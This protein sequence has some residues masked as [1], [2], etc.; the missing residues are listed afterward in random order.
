MT[1]YKYCSSLPGLDLPNDSDCY[2]PKSH[3]PPAFWDTLSK[4]WLTEDALRE[5]NRR[6]SL[7]TSNVPGPQSSE[8][9]TRRPVTRQIF[10]ERKRNRR[11]TQ[12]AS[13]FLRHCGRKTLKDIK[14]FARNGG[15]DLSDLTGVSM[16]YEIYSSVNEKKLMMMMLLSSRILFTFLIPQ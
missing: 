11:V 10:A 14:L 9:K 12:S 4:I 16:H 13:D 6:N 2:I 8:K 7:F 15:P 3:P 1:G 5:L